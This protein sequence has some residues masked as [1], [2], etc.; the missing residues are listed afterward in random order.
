VVSVP[1]TGPKGRR[2]EP[3]QGDRFLR[4]IKIRSKLF[5]GWEVKPDV[6]CHKIFRR[7]K[8]F[9]SPI[10]TDRLNSHFLHLFSYSLQRFL[11]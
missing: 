1:A 6:L 3:G 7:V 4:A 11:C 9:L 5:F 10:G 8:D 2:F